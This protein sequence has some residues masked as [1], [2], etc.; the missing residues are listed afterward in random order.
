MKSFTVLTVVCTLT[1]PAIAAIVSGNP[2]SDAGWSLVGHS[3]E[4]GVYVTGNANYGYNAYGTGFTVQAGS[5]LEI[6]DGEYSWMAGD[7]VLGVGGKFVSITAAQAGWSAFSGNTVNS[8]LSAD[9]GPKLQVKFGTSNATW[10][11][12]TVAPD[13]GNGD[14][15]S[16]AGGGRIQ[17]RTS[18]WNTASLWQASSGLL[19]P[20]EEDGHILWS[21]GLVDRRFA[22]VVWAFDSVTQEVSSWELLLNV[23]L[24][25]R[26]NPAYEELLPDIGDLAI[27]TVQDRESSYTDALVTTIPEPA[28]LALLGIGGLLLRRKK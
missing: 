27:M 17:I 23:S 8:L 16:S 5:N 20:L 19:L 25:A 18:G 26:L 14:S 9:N 1:L 2:D 21:G 12:S 15:S 24:V 4:N 11:T 10:S 6:F 7:T 22:R 13:S 28:T 3:L